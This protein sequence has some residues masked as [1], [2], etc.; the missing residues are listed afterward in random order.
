MVYQYLNDCEMDAEMRVNFR[1]LVEADHNIQK[2]EAG[3]W[4]RLR[5][6]IMLHLYSKILLT[7]CPFPK[8]NPLIN[9][10][11]AR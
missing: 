9:N 4:E 11:A 5:S 2:E 8:H 3:S 6:H 10:V 7:L 1:S